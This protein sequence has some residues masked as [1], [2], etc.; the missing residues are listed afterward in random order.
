MAKLDAQTIEKYQIILS[1]DPASQ[2]FAP[3]AESYREMGLHKEAEKVAREGIKR[4]PQFVSGLV[5]LA[6]ILRDL[7]KYDE[8]LLHLKKAISLA[9]EN[10]LAHQVCGEIHLARREPKE[11]LKSFKM[12]LFMNPH[13]Q[14]AKKA[15]QKLESLTA[16][17]YDD[18]LFQMA[19]LNTIKPLDQKNDGSQPAKTTPANAP[20]VVLNG[21]G[22]TEGALPRGMERVLSLID[23]FIVRN[24]L[25]KAQWMLEDASKEYGQHPEILRRS[26]ALRS[27]SGDAENL[28]TATPLRPLQNRKEASKQKRI[29]TLELLLR[30]IEDYRAGL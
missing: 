21:E 25:E 4:H 5:T 27:R 16:D 8:A 10:I 14:S 11:A 20:Q 3:L 23:A 13:S 26:K 2:V 18:E 28:D 1:K 24:D 6:K 19:K 12:V 17:E 9:S 7:E 30:R 15:V 29:E 22:K